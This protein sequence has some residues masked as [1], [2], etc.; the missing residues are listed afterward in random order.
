[1]KAQLRKLLSYLLIQGRV[2]FLFGKYVWG[3]YLLPAIS[4]CLSL[5]NETSDFLVAANAIDDGEHVMGIL[6]GI[7]HSFFRT[8]SQLF[9][10]ITL[11]NLAAAL[12]NY[13]SCSI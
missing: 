10:D 3:A 5:W 11:S 1:M 4:I 6:I 8:M 13:E 12:Q 2:T 9:T 7:T